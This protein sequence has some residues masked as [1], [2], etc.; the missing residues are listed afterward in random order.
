[1]LRASPSGSPFTVVL[2]LT[3]SNWTADR[4]TSMQERIAGGKGEPARLQLIISPHVRVLAATLQSPDGS[5]SPRNTRPR[6]RDV[7]ARSFRMQYS[8]G[9]FETRAIRSRRATPG[10]RC[11]CARVVL[12][13]ACRLDR[14]GG[15]YHGGGAR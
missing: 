11:L 9:I 14:Q 13:N 4:I 5:V 1:M 12:A 8:A 7:R 3:R 10:K 15:T 6:E 2:K